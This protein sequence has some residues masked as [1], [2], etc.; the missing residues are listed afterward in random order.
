MTWFVARPPK[1]WI[2]GAVHD[3]TGGLVVSSRRFRGREGSSLASTNPKRVRVRDD[4]PLLEGTWLYGGHWMRHFGHF[5]TETVTTLWPEQA[6]VDGLVFHGDTGKP[7]SIPEWQQRL[8]AYAGYGDLPIHVV[9][10][11]AV[12]VQHVLV[13]SRSI[14]YKS[15]GP[16]GGC[17]V[18]GRIE[19]AIGRPSYQRRVFLSRSRY[20]AM[21][22]L[23]SATALHS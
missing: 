23:K 19:Q 1:H 15:L 12:R 10:R 21:A 13:P 8:V 6:R 22:T 4:V 5:I 11:D 3:R 17:P 16:P 2:S 14:V 18:W 20:N 7:F 9:G